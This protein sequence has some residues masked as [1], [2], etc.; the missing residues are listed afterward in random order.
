MSFTV[1]KGWSR[2]NEK[3]YIH[4]TGVRI[5][6]MTYRGNDGWYIVPVDLDQPLIPFDATSEGQE[7]AFE[8]YATGALKEKSKTKPVSKKKPKA[9]PV[10]EPEEEPAE[11]DIESD[12]EEEESDEAEAEEEPGKE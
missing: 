8:A 10:P 3:L 1:P 11:K 7:K 5:Q 4:T 2:E 6:R 9:A 12:D